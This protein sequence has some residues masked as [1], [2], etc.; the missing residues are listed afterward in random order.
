M[1]GDDDDDDDDEDEDED[2]DED[3]DDDDDD[4]DDDGAVGGAWRGPGTMTRWRQQA[5][6]RPVICFGHW[7]CSLSGF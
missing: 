7:N 3:A 4:D 5:R 1:D 6:L 2:E